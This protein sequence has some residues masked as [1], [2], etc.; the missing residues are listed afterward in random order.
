LKKH[1][2]SIIL[3]L[4]AIALV[5]LLSTPINAQTQLILS[6][7]GAYVDTSGKLDTD[8]QDLGIY[9]FQVGAKYPMSSDS[10]LQKLNAMNRSETGLGKQSGWI[11]FQFM[12]DCEGKLVRNVKLIQTDTNHKSADFPMEGIDKLY[13]F[14]LSLSGWK[15]ASLPNNT[16]CS[17]HT[18]FSFKINHGKVE[19]IIP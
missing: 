10:L 13:Q 4:G 1:K 8:C 19:R 17:Y 16:A 2:S 18:F 6:P 3:F 11:T 12:I 9:Y 15:R 14:I 7:D 5:S